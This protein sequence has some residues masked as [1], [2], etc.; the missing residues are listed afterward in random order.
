[1][2]SAEAA[3]VA[4]SVSSEIRMP[5]NAVAAPPAAKP[6]S[7]ANWNVVIVTAVPSR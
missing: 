7:W 6:M 1:M 5:R 4:A 2:S 3:K